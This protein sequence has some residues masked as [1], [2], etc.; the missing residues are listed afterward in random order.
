LARL[1]IVDDDEADR[2]VL[3]TI[4][5]RAQHEVFVATDGDE[6]LERCTGSGID[7][8][9]TDLQM[10]HVHGLELIS[11]LRD[12]RPRPGIIAISGTGEDQLDMA[13]A[14]GAEMTLSKPVMPDQLLAA[15]A[16][17]LPEDA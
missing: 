8:V 4:L 17:V 11:R 2:V 16:A 14:L 3:K 9:I 15:L 12:L 6:A 7:A 10:Q 1:L 5:E 13:R